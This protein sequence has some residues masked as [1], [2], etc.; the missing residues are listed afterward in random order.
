MR[1]N[2]R[3]FRWITILSAILNFVTS[4]VCV[5]SNCM[6]RNT[7]QFRWIKILN[8]TV[9]SDI[10]KYFLCCIEL[11]E[12]QHLPVQMDKNIKCDLKFCDQYFICFWAG[13]GRAVGHRAREL[14][15]AKFPHEFKDLLLCKD[16]YTNM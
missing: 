12:T 6:R 15:L 4:T 10:I 13:G 14:D 16:L 1:R 5:T 2:T 7:R 3:Q 11:N 8:A 9:N